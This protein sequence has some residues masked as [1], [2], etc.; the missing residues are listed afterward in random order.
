MKKK[1]VIS[2]LNYIALITLTTIYGILD[3]LIL[4]S[5]MFNVLG[6][7]LYIYQILNIKKGT[8]NMKVVMLIELLIITNVYLL[9][10]G[11]YMPLTNKEPSE[12]SALILLFGVVALYIYNN[13]VK[14]LRK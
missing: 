7:A 2:T 13:F 3:N 8:N 4:Q 12:D 10:G 11:I 1:F 14:P 6:T 9:G 5:L